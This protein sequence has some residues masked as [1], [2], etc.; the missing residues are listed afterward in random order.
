MMGDIT[1][2]RISSNEEFDF[3]HLY[4]CDDDVYQHE[5]ISHLITNNDCAY[6][7]PAEFQNI[8]RTLKGQLSLF[9]LNCRSLPAHWNDIKDLLASMSNSD[10]SFD[11]IGLSEVFKL[12]DN[13]SYSL[14]G[15]H[16]IISRTRGPNDDGRGGV[17]LFL[18][19]YFTYKLREDLSVFIPHVF[20]SIFVEI[21]LPREK[22]IIVGCIYRPNTLPLADVDIC[23]HNL[24]EIVD[25]VN[26]ER[27]SLF[28][29]GDFNVDLLNY[30]KQRK[31]TNFVDHLFGRGILPLITKPTRITNHSATVIDHIHTS[32]VKKNFKSGIIVSDVAD[33]FGTFTVMREYYVPQP[34]QT[35]SYR[36]FSDNSLEKFRET[37][38]NTN[39][40]SVLECPSANE[41][42]NLFLDIYKEIFETLFPIKT[43][44]VG[45]R[46]VKKESW[47]T[48]GLLQSANNK[49]KLLKIKINK[50]TAANIAKYKEYVKIFN[51]TKRAAQ[52]RYYTEQ[53]ELYKQD[54]KSTWKI[55]SE[56]IKKKKTNR[57]FPA[58]FLINNSKVTNKAEVAAH[59]NDFFVNIGKTLSETLATS[60][61][62][63]KSYLTSNYPINFFLNPV[64]P[65][66]VIKSAT[67]LKSK[68]STGHDD[69]STKLMKHTI[70]E[71][72][73]P[74]SHIFNLSFS[75]GIVPDQMKIAK[76]VPIYKQGDE[77]AL[78]NY[79]PVSIL[80]AFSKL[81]EKIVCNRL[82]TFLNINNIFYE[83]QYGFRPRHSTVHPIFHL[84][85][86]TVLSNDKD[87]KDFTVACCIDLSKAFD[88]VSHNILLNKL[89]YYGVRGL[90]NDW[91][92][93]YLS[94][95]YQFTQVENYKS[96]IES[97]S[98]GVPQGSI[99]GPLLFLIY[100]NDIWMSC[101]LK[102][103]SF[104]DDTTVLAH[105]HNEISVT[106]KLNKE[107]SNLSTWLREN[108]LTLNVNKTKC[109]FISPPGKMINDNITLEIE[110]KSVER[111]S[112]KNSEDL[113]FLGIYLDEHLSW[114]CHIDYTTK[115]LSKT[116]YV[117]NMAKNILPFSAL[118]ILYHTLVESCITYGIT[119]WGN[120]NS[121]SKIEKLKKQAMRIIYKKPYRA[122]CDPLFRQSGILKISD[123]YKLTM[124]LLAFDYKNDLLPQS[125]I[126]FYP[127]Q[128]LL[129][130]EHITFHVVFLEQLFLPNRCIILLL[131][132][133]IN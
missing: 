76:V 125:F 29:T 73:Q 17:A 3:K 86:D 103:L 56:V 95:R 69:I 22:N 82:Y 107:L 48:L 75:T 23:C 122:H 127:N 99:L 67:Q 93:S 109:L 132:Y 15:Y 101:G 131:I 77:H 106:N 98:C 126:D 111:V 78:N 35:Q 83:H 57:A 94:D 32:M 70:H 11:I 13:V 47:M 38:R 1:L 12:R 10:F 59:F 112:N 16:D 117:M 100:V 27:K 64:I 31:T 18:K 102:V 44:Q 52:S 60:P 61:S 79:R 85:K 55:L 92:N 54:I 8:S 2:D 115:K 5:S 20:E 121:M 45:K 68:T 71:T 105:G 25:L 91:M 21:I 72:A 43:K 96:S 124:S 104:A 58:F 40:D 118:K 65:F 81:I 80:P 34:A 30:S 26:A 6:Y 113:K 110:G 123:Y 130:D 28:L 87:T 63:F 9:S 128:T 66:D 119:V 97:I 24:L 19:D 116:L 7:S 88:T 36:C 39:F 133:G 37:L 49:H 53:L 90:S 4:E 42:Y 120:S 108:R 33:H 129:L 14:E 46:F 51:R 84:I 62:K 50:P 41:A 74:F 89:H 114:N